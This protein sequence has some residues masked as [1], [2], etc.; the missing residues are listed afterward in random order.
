MWD[1]VVLGSGPAGSTVA[2]LL[3]R[4]GH[5]VCIVARDGVHPRAESLPPSTRNLFELLGIQ[6]RITAAGFYTDG[7]NTSWWG[8]ES[9]REEHFAAGATGWHV[10]RSRFDQLLLD[11]A[12]E[13]GVTVGADLPVSEDRRFIID[14]SGRAGLLAREHRVPDDRYRTVCLAG[15]W[16]GVWD[17]EPTHA[18]VE[19]YEDGWAWSVP[20]GPHVRHLAFMVD[21]G[22][23]RGGLMA[24]YQA[25]L[26]KTRVL[27]PMFAPCAM[28]GE[29]WAADASLYRSRQYAGP[30]WMLV[31]DAG[32]AVDPLSSFGVKKALI[33][34]WMGAVV[35][36]TCLRKPDLRDHAIRMFNDREQQTY[37]DH[38]RQSA[39]LFGE[40]TERFPTSFWKSR[41]VLSPDL[42]LYDP[43]TLRQAYEELKDAPEIRLKLR[44]P[45]RLERAP[46][47][48]GREVVLVDRLSLPGLASTIEYVQGV[49]LVELAR[50]CEDYRQVPDLFEAYNRT[51]RPVALSNFISALSFLLA[52]GVMCNEAAGSP[53]Q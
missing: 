20:L 41:A 42:Q 40:L 27:G 47:I 36:N 4:W 24:G 50:L 45:L 15:R 49:N 28:E 8:G 19:A 10:E 35:V 2:R 31:G 16:R 39:L 48:A 7:G 25:E 13:E 12:R 37:A 33:S 17:A 46:A 21:H 51:S 30:D 1:V 9:P 5:R 32:F 34:A 18:L 52:S 26:A 23:K 22:Q 43:G 53:A 38:A 29:P 11:L 44:E 6:D 14:C 3:A